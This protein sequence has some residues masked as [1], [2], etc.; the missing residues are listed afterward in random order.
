MSV[1]QTM[2]E[3][4]SAGVGR[5]MVTVT[6]TGVQPKLFGRVVNA[7]VPVGLMVST[8]MVSEVTVVVLPALS[9]M[10]T[11]IAFTPCGSVTSTV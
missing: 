5:R 10:V 1:T 2:P 4:G 3:S 6:V 7:I 8:L 11:V 9:V